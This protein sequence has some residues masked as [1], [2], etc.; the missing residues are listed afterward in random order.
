[1]RGSYDSEESL[2]LGGEFFMLL[3]KRSRE[4]GTEEDADMNGKQGAE[5]GA[6][7]DGGGATAAIAAANAGTGNGGVAAMDASAPIA[8]VNG[9]QINTTNGASNGAAD[10]GGG[11]DVHID[12][13]LHSRQLAVYG[14]ESMRRMASS[15]ILVSGMRGL[16]AEVAKNVILAGVRAVTLHDEGAAEMKDLCAQFYLTEADVGSNRATACKERLQELNTS[17]VVECAAACALDE[18]VIAN[19]NVVV[20]LDAPLAEATRV[21]AICRAQEPAISFVYGS[22]A[23]LTG[24]VFCDFGPSFVVL[25]TDGEEPLSAIISGISA[26]EGTALVSCVDDERLE[27]QD[28]MKV[29]F[30]EVKGM[31]ELNDGKPRSIK[32][33]KAHSFELADDTCEGYNAYLTGGVVTQVKEPKTLVFKTMADALQEPGEFLMSDFSKLDRATVLHICLRALDAFKAETGRFPIAHEEA[34][35]AKVVS[36]A[37]DVD[38]GMPEAYRLGEALDEK[39]V[40]TYAQTARGYVNP[41]AAVLGG[42]I[43]QEVVKAC[44][45]KFHPLLQ[46]FHFDS[47]ESLPAELPSAED[48]AATGDRYEGQTAIFGRGFQD[49][50]AASR[51]FLVGAGALGCEFLK[52]FACMGLSCGAPGLVTLTDDDSIEKSNLSRQFLFRDWNIGQPKSTVAAAAACAINTSLNVKALQNRVSPETEEVFDD[53][54]W[55]SLDFVVNALD[56]VTARLYVDARC[57]YFK[58]ALLESGTLGTKCNTQMVIPD[59]TEN[60]G[61]SRDPPE[62]QAPMCTLHS[63]PHNI[64]HCLTWA[65]SEFEGMMEANPAE[66]NAYLE[67][68]EGFLSKVRETGDATSRESLEKVVDCLVDNRCETFEDCIAWARRKLQDYFHNRIAQL[69]YTFPEDYATSSGAPF[70]SP[71]KRFPV[72]IQFSSDDELH[73]TFVMAAANLKAE[74]HGVEK[75]TWA[76]DLSAVAAKAKAVVVEKFMPQSGVK[77]ETDPKAQSAKPATAQDDDTVIELLA[78]KLDGAAKSIPAEMRLSPIEF[79]KDDDTNYHMDM[80]S[81]LA[82]LRARNYRIPEVDKLKAKF[83]AGKIIPAIATTTALATGLVCLELYKV[84]LR[85]PI[86][87]F[88]NTFATLALPLFAMAEPVES[89]FVSF[90]DMKWSLWDRWIIEGDISVAELLEWFKKKG[91]IAYS[92]S[93]GPTMLYNMLFPKHKE[94]LPKKVSDVVREI[95]KVTLPPSRKY[96]DLVIACEDEEENDVDV[97]LVSIKFRGS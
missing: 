89:K 41:M 70:W 42:L 94:R 26:S 20:M 67:N 37:K 32:N 86:E 90:G 81:S 78:S 6:A 25:D 56:N 17:V 73:V 72:A 7:G 62:K 91:L 27:F 77:I 4:D 95:A 44:S 97:P 76:G 46:W 66:A 31:E 11:G 69:V 39:I 51:T 29:S 14:R 79:E 64:S 23:G 45:G 34:D 3:G 47:F 22:T 2:A 54:F 57:V 60:Y 96:I 59:M 61:A 68:R 82:N 18:T 35:I 49:K 63:F 15:K 28:G 8:A 36:I 92:V 24:A 16:G 74:I 40:R 38:D 88:R 50:L 80:I 52:N 65:R 12:E 1:M 58:R 93:C 43:G 10:I 30:A 71:P 33:V 85:K 55:E 9:A 48:M 21:N 84:V 5:G 19:H 75:P 13:N 53:S 87:A 83:I